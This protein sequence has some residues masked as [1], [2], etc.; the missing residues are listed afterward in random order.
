MKLSE[1]FSLS[2][3][4]KSGTA[5]RK[6]IDNTPGETEIKN[7]VLLCDTVLEPIREHFEIPFVPS[8]GFRC[9]E[10]NRAIGSADTSQHVMGKA[11]DFEIPGIDNQHVAWWI[12]AN[13]IFDQLILEFYKED[14][15][16]SGWVH[17]SFDI[18]KYPQRRTALI[19]DGK[20]WSPLAEDRT[21]F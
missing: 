12:Q 21:Y 3:L 8:S 11:V 10:L 17:C 16:S 7:L 4:T 1:H 9:L 2:E 13:C 14:E 19:F 15:P 6:G 20:H 18:N 5:A